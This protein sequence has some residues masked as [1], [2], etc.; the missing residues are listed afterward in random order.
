MK[1]INLALQGGGAL[2]AYTWGVLDRL[3]EE[4]EIQIEGISGTSAGAI[5]A[6]VLATGYEQRGNIGAKEA[7][8]KLWRGIADLG[9]MSMLHQTPLEHS[10]F[11]WNLDGTV[12]YTLMDTMLK[13]LSPYEFNPANVNFF[14]FLLNE[15]IDFELLRDSATIKLFL[16]ATNVKT[17]RARI[18]NTEEITIDVLLASSCLPRVFQAVEIKG[19]YYW[20]GGY[21]GN[22]S[23]WPLIYG[24]KSQDILLVQINPLIRHQLPR[25]AYEIIDRV[26]EI[27]FNSSLISEMR[28]INFISKLIKKNSIDKNVYKDLYIHMIESSED[29]QEL[30]AS[31]KFHVNWDFFLFL[32]EIGRNAADIWLRDNAQYIG[33]TSSLDIEQVFF[34]SGVKDHPYINESSLS[35]ELDM[36]KEE[37]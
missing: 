34:P 13:L 14:K 33:K 16:A 30:N 1:K 3:L 21:M 29:M 17:G 7:L 9:K 11:G 10:L 23:L 5:N 15:I 8:D 6:A 37:K 36:P 22:P 12:S 28:A 4:K 27:S 32:K 2:G 26:S 18:F 35:H 24:C 19:E 25:K 31:S 20:D